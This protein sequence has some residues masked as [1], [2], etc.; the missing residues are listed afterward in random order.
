MVRAPVGAQ[1]SR[2]IP[3][4][5]RFEWNSNVYFASDEEFYQEV[6]NEKGEVVYEVVEM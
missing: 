4:A 5:S 1:F 2:L 6:D 3:H